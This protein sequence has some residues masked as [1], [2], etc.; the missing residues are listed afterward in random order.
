M[1]LVEDCSH[2]S[3]EW[4]HH[5]TPPFLERPPL[6]WKGRRQH[7]HTGSRLWALKGFVVSTATKTS[8]VVLPG[9]SNLML[10]IT[11][12]L[13]G[14]LVLVQESQS[15]LCIF[16]IHHLCCS[17][18][19]PPSHIGNLIVIITI[20]HPPEP[21]Q[22]WRGWHHERNLQEP[23]FGTSMFHDSFPS[24]QTRKMTARKRAPSGYVILFV[25]LSFLNSI[26]SSFLFYGISSLIEALF[27]TG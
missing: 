12:I 25:G 15:F 7:V 20:A 18:L 11:S 23:V 8:G 21:T 14:P 26:S 1:V 9:H 3:C 4:P 16:L 2:R 24:H 17:R 5:T 22:S 6:A 10:A 27:L 19:S 13:E